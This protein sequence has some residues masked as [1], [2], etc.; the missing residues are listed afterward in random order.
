M[1][2]CLTF[3]QS[4]GSGI[5]FLDPD[6][7][8]IFTSFK[9]SIFFS[10][11]SFALNTQIPEHYEETKHFQMHDFLF[12]LKQTCFIQWNVPIL[13]IETDMFYSMKCTCFIQWNRHVLFNETYMFYSVKY[14]Y[15][16]YLHI[17]FN[18]T[19]MFYLVK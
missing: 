9:V 2:E 15:E 5:I 6:P 18:E 7:G 10:D 16:T 1:E 13:L 12:N 4:C 19:Y 3:N 14:N 17:L 11:I 8:Q